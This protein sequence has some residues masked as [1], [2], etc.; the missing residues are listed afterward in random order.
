MCDAEP[1]RPAGSGPLAER[2]SLIVVGPDR[3]GRF[4]GARGRADRRSVVVEVVAG[5]R[6]T[7]LELHN[8]QV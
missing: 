6:R 4:V 8:M 3:R 1:P 7:V 5:G 2:Y